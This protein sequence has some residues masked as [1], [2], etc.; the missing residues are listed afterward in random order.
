MKMATVMEHASCNVIYV[1]KRAKGD[2]TVQREECPRNGSESVDSS[3]MEVSGEP[4]EV[5]SNIQ[6]LLSTFKQGKVMNTQ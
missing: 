5:T 6:A 3:Y 4:R 1:D 2:R